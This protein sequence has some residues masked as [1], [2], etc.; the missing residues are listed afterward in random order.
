M[1]HVI[2]IQLKVFSTYSLNMGRSP[3]F[4]VDEVDIPV[5]KPTCAAILRTLQ[6][7]QHVRFTYDAN[8]EYNQRVYRTVSSYGINT[9]SITAEVL[10]VDEIDNDASLNKLGIRA[11]AFREPRIP[12][13][14]HIYTWYVTTDGYVRECEHYGIMKMLSSVEV[15]SV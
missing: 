14:D 7:G 12:K 8:A 4:N 11:L 6:P 10:V 3:F 15:L 2:P 13:H 1:Y 5:V 9:S